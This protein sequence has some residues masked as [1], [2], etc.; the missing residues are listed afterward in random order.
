MIFFLKLEEDIVLIPEFPAEI[1]AL[2]KPPPDAED[3]N[4]RIVVYEFRTEV[5]LA[6]AVAKDAL[7]L[8]I[9]VL[10]KKPEKFD[11]KPKIASTKKFSR[12]TK[13]L[14]RSIIKKRKARQERVLNS[15]SVDL[16][17]YLSNALALRIKKLRSDKTRAVQGRKSRERKSSLSKTK[18]SVSL[19]RQQQNSVSSQTTV[20]SPSIPFTPSQYT[21]PTIS[22]ITAA[23]TTVSLKSN[24]SNTSISQVQFSPAAALSTTLKSSSRSLVAIKS[25]PAQLFQTQ[26]KN[27]PRALG[28]RIKPLLYSP[29]KK[30]KKQSSFRVTQRKKTISYRIRLKESELQ[31]LGSFYL[32]IRLMTGKGVKI[33]EIG[34]IVSHSEKLNAFLT[35][36]R[37]PI[38]EASPIKAGVI[39][40][41]VKQ[42]DRKAKAIRVFR[43]IAPGQVAST[44]RGSPWE[45]IMDTAL[46]ADDDELRFKDRIGS[47]KPIM[48]RALCYGENAKAAEDF[49][50]TI[51]LPLKKLIPDQTG[52]LTATAKFVK[53]YATIIVSDIPDDVVAVGVKRYNVTH[54][55]ISSKK[56]LTGPGFIFVG[57][58]EEAKIVMVEGE[59]HGVVARFKDGTAKPGNK[60]RY[61]PIGFTKAGKEISGTQAILELSIGSQKDK[62]SLQVKAPVLAASEGSSN[63]TMDVSAQFTDFGFEEV[64]SLLTAGSQKSLFNDDLESNRD[65]FKGLINFL[66]E[67]ENFRSGEVESFGVMEAGIFEDSQSIREE[68]N[69]K[70]LEE[71]TRY[72]Y[73]VTALLRSADTLFPDLASTKVDPTTLLKYS[74]RIAKF[75]NPLALDQSTLQSTSRQTDFTKPSKIE[76]TDP[77]LAGRTNAQ[78]VFE[79]QVPVS[80]VKSGEVRIDRFYKFN[81]I[82]W[83]YQGNL[84]AI[85]HFQVFILCAGG[86]Q[87]IDTIHC[88]DASAIFYYRHFHKEYSVAYK[89]EVV[90]IS[91]VYKPLK[92]LLSKEIKPTRYNKRVTKNKRNKR[93]VKI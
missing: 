82:S 34:R 65:K 17:A 19:T 38:I 29:P 56:A 93:V 50:S 81:R 51:V 14:E 89:Y 24:P 53:T 31:K 2:L 45:E 21:T 43:R 46:L 78:Q 9:D 15:H 42:V 8:R 20:I 70:P 87:L 85:D 44:D 76:P 62:V 86:K 57:E 49:G 92:S 69:V 10:P 47:S 23:R 75:R 83:G 39:S 13:T 63:V 48:Y 52:A 6:R 71:G 5:D 91:L 68:K 4:D 32:R 37:A 28:N 7:T 90:P 59:T 18:A 3:K 16:T 60:Y 30:L 12:K 27:L 77:F 73:K 61:V 79:V 74:S 26:P 40:I 22:G 55:S 58:V 80:S 66:V 33:S 72:A 41:G 1:K 54:S 64:Q 88:D 67:R 11:K 35:P 25:D 84:Q 36:R